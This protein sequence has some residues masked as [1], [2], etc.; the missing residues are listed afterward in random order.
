[1]GN[2]LVVML[3]DTFLHPGYALRRQLP[4]CGA[5]FGRPALGGVAQFHVKATSPPLD[6]HVAQR[7]GADKILGRVGIQHAG[8]CGQRPCSVRDMQFCTY[9]WWGL[10]KISSV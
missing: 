3:A 2:D 1:M 5:A 6:L 8:K 10:K 9:G 7:A 4:G